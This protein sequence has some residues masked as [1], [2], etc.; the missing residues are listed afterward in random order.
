M[1]M[2]MM[3]MMLM[4]MMMMMMMLMLMMMMMLMLMMMMFTSKNRG[5]GEFFTQENWRNGEILGES[6]EKNNGKLEQNSSRNC[7]ISVHHH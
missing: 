2:M 7:M 1:M 6:P 3:M 4:M 5:F